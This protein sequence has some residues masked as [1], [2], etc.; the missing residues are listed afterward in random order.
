LITAATS[1]FFLPGLNTLSFVV[2]NA[3]TFGDPT[4]PPFSGPTGLQVAILS[5]D[6][7]LVPEPGSGP[8]LATA[9]VLLAFK[10]RR[11]SS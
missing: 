11:R 1:P 2:G 5:A 7:T 4:L 6:A 9:L 10:A 3:D 8:L